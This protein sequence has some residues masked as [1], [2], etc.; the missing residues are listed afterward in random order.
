[1]P[2]RF[3]ITLLNYE[4]SARLQFAYSPAVSVDFTAEIE[5]SSL[6]FVGVLNFP[7]DLELAAVAFLEDKIFKLQNLANKRKATPDELDTLERE[8]EEKNKLEKELKAK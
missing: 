3:Y 2:T 4:R 8:R 5:S 7:D 1:Q 6:E